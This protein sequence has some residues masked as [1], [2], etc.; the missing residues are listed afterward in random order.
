MSW[1]VR[2]T[3]K[4]SL[5][6]HSLSCT[7]SHIQRAPTGKQP[8]RISEGST[9][10]ELSW[11]DHRHTEW[12]YTLIGYFT[13]HSPC[14]WHRRSDINPVRIQVAVGDWSYYDLL[15][16]TTTSIKTGLQACCCHKVIIIHRPPTFSD[17]PHPYVPYIYVR[18][19]AYYN[20][21]IHFP[22][23]LYENNLHMVK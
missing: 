6:A 4:R 5:C 23:R 19:C 20:V 13:T 8:Y 7:V 21:L 2:W 17:N 3:V 16:F 18:P 10:H 15:K 1:S 12:S 22:W 11:L 9:E 14:K